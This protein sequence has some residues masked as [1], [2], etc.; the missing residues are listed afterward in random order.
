M[1]QRRQNSEPDVTFHE[2]FLSKSVWVSQIIEFLDS[3]D[4]IF[5]ES[6][7]HLEDKIIGIHAKSWGDKIIN[8]ALNIIISNNG[9]F[10]SQVISVLKSFV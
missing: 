2:S 5:E 7:S 9:F 10:K 1:Q 3:K 6:L 4:L 8:F